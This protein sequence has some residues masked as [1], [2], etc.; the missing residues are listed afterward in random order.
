MTAG[1]RPAWGASV[2][3][4]A[5]SLLSGPLLAPRA[6]RCGGGPRGT[7]VSVAPRVMGGPRLPRNRWSPTSSSR[8]HV[9]ACRTARDA[10][11]ALR[12]CPLTRCPPRHRQR[13]DL[14]V[15]PLWAVPGQEGEPPADSTPMAWR[16]VTTV[17]VDTVADASQRGEGD[18]CRWGLEVWHR[19]VQ[20]GCRL[21]ERQRAS[22]ERL[23]RCLTLSSV[24]AGRIFLPRCWRG[25]CRTCHGAWGWTSMNGRRCLVPSLS[26]RPHRRSPR[27]G[28]RPCVG[29]PNSAVLSAAPPR[30]TRDGNVVAG[31]ATLHG[32]HPNVSYYAAQAA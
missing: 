15:V 9:V 23:P 32:P 14:P 24:R 12:F 25:R 2:T 20:S 8:C 5:R 30:L 16:L 11:L 21:A 18:A 29:W 7:A 22:G 3:G 31:L 10:P 17:P 13:A 6:S 1:R 27:R 26:A 4:K 28:S 19:L